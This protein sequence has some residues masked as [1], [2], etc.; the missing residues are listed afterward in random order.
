MKIAFGNVG[1]LSIIGLVVCVRVQSVVGDDMV[2]E[3][4]LKVFLAV[5]TEQEAVD[6]RAKL[7]EGKV[8]GSEEGSSHVVRCIVD[9]LKQVGFDE[10]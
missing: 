9:S 4:S 8:G 7:L 3:E 2:L 1:H 5:A 10:C 6:S